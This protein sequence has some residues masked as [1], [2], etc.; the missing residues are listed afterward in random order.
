MDDFGHDLDG[1]V[2]AE[3]SLGAMLCQQNVKL[4]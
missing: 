1:F 2:N 4:A 3:A